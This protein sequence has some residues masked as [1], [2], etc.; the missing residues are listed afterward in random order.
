MLGP[1]LASRH[2]E[3]RTGRVETRYLE[4]AAEERESVLARSAPEI[5]ER[6]WPAMHVT[7]EDALK[8]RHIPLVVHEPVVQEV[9][10]LREA[11]VRSTGH[12]TSERPSPYDTMAFESR[13]PHG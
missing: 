10:I 11:V 9:V 7:T 1:R 6:P 13:G 2:D 4:P 12:S 5:E 8:E 3:H